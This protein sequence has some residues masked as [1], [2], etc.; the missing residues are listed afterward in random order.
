MGKKGTKTSR[1]TIAIRTE[2]YNKLG[3]YAGPG[4]PLTIQDYVEA[5]LLREWL[6]ESMHRKLL[7]VDTSET[8]GDSNN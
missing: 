2:I 1:K 7:K 8:V 6:T 5:L 3:K 4:K